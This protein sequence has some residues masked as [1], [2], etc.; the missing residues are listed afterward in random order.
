MKY[1]PKRRK[2]EDNLKMQL[3]WFCHK[4][5][6][7]LEMEYQHEN[8]RFDAVLIRRGEILAIIEVKNWANID[9]ARRKTKKTPKQF[10]KYLSFGLPV[11]VLWKVGGLKT[12]YNRLKSMANA[13]DSIGK[14]EGSKLVYFPMIKPVS[15][16]KKKHDELQKLIR[17][18]K[19][20]S[21]Y[22]YKAW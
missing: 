1:D 14:T 15:D 22:N 8:C 3:N 16:R 20:E 21:N 2:H 9:C 6:I 18:Q 13:Y 7:Y 11:L 17:Q 10:E 4:S 5:G 19:S 12:L